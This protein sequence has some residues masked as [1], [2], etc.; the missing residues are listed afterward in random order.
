METRDLRTFLA[1]A[2]T[3]SITR[4]A[5]LLDRSQPSVTRTIQDLE[6]ELGLALLQRVGRRIMLSEEG[7]AFEEEARRVLNSLS[8]LATRARAIA[9]G[10][11][12]MLQVASTS[13]IATAL[14][15]P[16]LAGF[17]VEA[18]PSEV[19]VAQYLPNVVA[20]EVRAGRAEIGFSSMPLDLP[21]LEVLRLYAANDV[22]AFPKG[23]PLSQYDVVPLSA[24]A[25]RRLVTMLDPT[26][27][28][29]RVA[30]AMEASDVRPGPVIRTNVS[31]SALRLVQKMG[32]VSIVDPVSAY[33]VTLPDV[34]IRPIDTAIPFYWG[35]VAA[36]ARP[37]RPLVA[38]LVEAVEAEALRLIPNLR[39]LDPSDAAQAC[40]SQESDA[41]A[42][43]GTQSAALASRQ[44]HDRGSR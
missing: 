27:F 39:M 2:E 5:A 20:Q 25:G 1:V 26:R 41:N 7:V 29:H 37:L 15:P 12:R 6:A 40:L 23:D 3:G 10:K 9:A 4:A 31:Y 8:G 36:M 42:P 28:Q 17:A 33:G 24:F 16:A 44:M 22:A 21:G 43:T 30:R 18:L 11:G 35:V 34:V 32:A 13:A 14:I 19:H 38:Q